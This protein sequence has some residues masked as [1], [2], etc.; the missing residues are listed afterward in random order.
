MKY[1]VGLTEEDFKQNKAW[2]KGALNHLVSKDPKNFLQKLFLPRP[3]LRSIFAS[4]ATT[5]TIKCDQ[6]VKTFYLYEFSKLF[7]MRLFYSGDNVLA[8]PKKKMVFIKKDKK[9][10]T[11]FLEQGNTKKKNK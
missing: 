3:R 1:F 2:F 4:E 10:N 5:L 7:F 11:F 6:E 9:G 8:E